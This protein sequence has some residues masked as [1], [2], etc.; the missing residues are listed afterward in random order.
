MGYLSWGVYYG[1]STRAMYIQCNRNTYEQNTQQCTHAVQ[2]RDKPPHTHPHTSTPANQHN[3][4]APWR[5]SI[6]ELYV[7]NCGPEIC[8]GDVYMDGFQGGQVHSC[9]G[10]SGLDMY[11]KVPLGG[12]IHLLDI[13][14]GDQQLGYGIIHAGS[15][16]AACLP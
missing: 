3:P 4:Q 5:K 15:S 12:H 16:A 10:N 11:W 9:S 6:P 2:P 7:C 13:G 14:H 1:V 8:L